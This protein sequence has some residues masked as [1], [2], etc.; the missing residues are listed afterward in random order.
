MLQNEYLKRVYEEVQRR[1][2]HEPE[3]LQ[4]VLEVFESLSLWSTSTPNGK[5]RACS[6]VSLSR[7][8]SWNSAF[9]GWTTTAIPV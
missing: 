6:S 1:D 2:S 9:P 7:S 5:K 4:A 3:F 8:V